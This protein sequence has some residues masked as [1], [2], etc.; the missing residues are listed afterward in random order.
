MLTNI[1]NCLIANV[2]QAIYISGRNENPQPLS[3][4]I[5]SLFFI[6]FDFA[7]LHKRAGHL[8]KRENQIGC[9][10]PI[11]MPVTKN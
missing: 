6:V 7:G 9:K 8:E 3:P 10:G 1:I 11:F 2:R 4:N 5:P